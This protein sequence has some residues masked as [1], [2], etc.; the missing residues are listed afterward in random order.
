MEVFGL[1]FFDKDDI[2]LEVLPKNFS[3][4]QKVVVPEVEL[5]FKLKIIID[6]E[7][8]LLG[9]EGACLEF[10]EQ[11]GATDEEAVQMEKGFSHLLDELEIS[12]DAQNK[13]SGAG[14]GLAA[15]LKLFFNAEE[16]MATKFIND[17]L[18]IHA[19]ESAA[20][21]VITGEGKLD[22]QTYLNKGAMIVVNEFASKNIPVF[23][24]CG[25]SDGDLPDTENLHVIEI[26][27]YFES[28]EE[29]IQKIDKGIEIACKKICKDIIRL[30]AK[31]NSN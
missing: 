21:I 2:Q 4:V 31:K 16:K 26:A 9:I 25:M 24:I 18:K 6:V 15:A 27:E 23:F 12:E 17:D 14:G 20:D 30:F 7:N 10:S 19:G 1:E 29:S 11:K 3:K 22:A 8:P 13:L 5:P 28:P